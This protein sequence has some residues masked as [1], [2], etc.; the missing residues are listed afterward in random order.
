MGVLA[1]FLLGASVRT[2][3]IRADEATCTNPVGRPT[4]VGA[5]REKSKDDPAARAAWFLKGR[6]Q[7]SR[8]LAGG[9]SVPPALKLLQSFQ[10]LNQMSRQPGL[11]AAPA[12][13][14]VLGPAPQSSLYWGNVS[15]R[16]TSL[17]VDLR[18]Q[19]HVLYVGTAFGG[20]WRT[21]DFT[22]AVPH[23]VSLGDTQW[24]SLAV[25]SIAV[26]TNRPIAQPPIIYVGTGE[27]NDS[28]DS[29]YGVGILKSSDGG[30][31]WSITT[32]KGKLVSLSASAEYE[33]DGPFVGAAISK[34]VIDPENPNH[35][36]VSVSSSQLGTTHS[37]KIAIY[38]S[39]N[40]GDSWQAMTLADKTAYN[41]TDLIYEPVQQA[42][43]AAVEGNGVYRL[44]ANESDWKATASP[45]G[46]TPTDGNNFYRASLATRATDRKPT[47]YAVI[48][49]G[50]FGDKD[51][52]NYNLSKPTANDTGI[53][54]S[55]DNGATWVAVEAPAKLFGDGQSD[56][57]GFYDQWIAVPS[58][59]EAMMAG[60]IDVW[61]KE[62]SSVSWTNL[63]NGYDWGDGL[64]HPNLHI[65]PDQH[66]I[67]VLDD[68]QWIVAND[69]GV[70]RTNDGGASWL[71]LNTDIS[72]IQLMSATPLRSAPNGY[73]GGSQDNGT[74]LSSATGLLWKTTL[75]GDGG[76]TL[77][78]PGQPAQYFTER[79]N[80]SLC[81]S[82]DSG[83]SWKTVV[84]GDA[85]QDAS[86][87]YV[88]YQLLRAGRDEIVLGTDRV[89]IGDAVPAQAGSAW[90][91][92]SGTLSP[93]GFVQ[94][95]AVAP[96]NP[97]IV[98]VA[99]SDSLVYLNTSIHASI[100][101]WSNIKRSNLPEGRPYAALAVD[102]Q[103]PKVAYIGV[104]GFGT[105]HLFRTDNSG[106]QWRDITPKVTVDRQAVQIDTPVNS[107]LI[108]PA[109]P[110]DVYVATDI[111]VFMSPDRGST[112]RPYSTGLP[113]SAVMDLKMT[114]DRKIL[115]ATHGRGAWIVSPVSH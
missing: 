73:L 48:S 45:F 106:A 69:G 100:P 91:F 35:V 61:R 74:A 23:F 26:E 50:Y 2:G 103:N 71:N 107:I 114:P 31:T 14:N 53:V 29:Y 1:L 18:N 42:F 85:I 54:Q 84:D 66:A 104:Q 10:Q 95:I 39:Q 115:S 77:D 13:W 67:V 21:D 82:D 59:T 79:F 37:P 90:R 58:G 60:G 46:L 15:G 20:L 8:G 25:G 64:V 5:T 112:W 32:G 93:N 63:T 41:T 38:E 51:P 96:S 86:P 78:N 111:G 113:R 27:A 75:T 56:G 109:F 3:E 101:R 87:F 6:K 7:S 4:G 80:I 81:R 28:L 9:A 83:K 49:A 52:R 55:S 62:N 72:S 98:Y 97:L 22:A 92:V 24:P 11:A 105:G 94:A 43:Y 47:I 76:F 36:L 108:D 40:A 110:S 12:S 16:V 102:P 17:A 34:I 44:A 89:W 68:R 33:L 99:T 30:S 57:Q 19:M 70:W 65:H 88:P